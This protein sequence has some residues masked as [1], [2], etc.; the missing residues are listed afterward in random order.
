MIAY[1]HTKSEVRIFIHSEDL[2]GCQYSYMTSNKSE[3]CFFI[4]TTVN[5]AERTWI[6]L[7]AVNG[8]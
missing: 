8:I 3:Q 6:L 2:D 7:I 5:T 4:I 1:L